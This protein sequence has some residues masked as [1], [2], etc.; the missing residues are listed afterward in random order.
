MPSA[1][2]LC[3]SSSQMALRP[4]YPPDTEQR[5]KTCVHTCYTLL[6]SNI[7]LSIF[8]VSKIRGN[9]LPNDNSCLFNMSAARASTSS[10]QTLCLGVVT[11]ISL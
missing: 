11:L 9:F 4:G 7:G 5:D 1:A 8:T 10:S 3:L 6:L 2:L